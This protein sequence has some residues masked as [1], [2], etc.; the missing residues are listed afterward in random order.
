MRIEKEKLKIILSLPYNSL[1]SDLRLILKD[2]IFRYEYFEKL[3]EKSE[4]WQ[5]NRMSF[6]IHAV[7]LLGELKAEESLNDILE[8]FR[9]GE[10]F[11][12]F[13]VW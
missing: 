4:K 10:E 5:E 6:P 3:A 7:Y 9:Q 12:E 13:L 2:T 11:I 8:T 1:V